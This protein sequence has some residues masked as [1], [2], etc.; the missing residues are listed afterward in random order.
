MLKIVL[1]LAVISIMD[2][3][4]EEGITLIENVWYETAVRLVNLAIK[5][6]KLDSEQASALRDVY[7]RPNDYQVS[8]RES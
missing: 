5:V 7:L 1:L 2:P 6:Y 8:L 4:T 3:R